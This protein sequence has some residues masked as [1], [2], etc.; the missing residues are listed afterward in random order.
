MIERKYSCW[1]RCLKE[2]WMKKKLFKVRLS[3]AWRLTWHCQDLIL[4]TD[5]VSCWVGHL[6]SFQVQWPLMW[7]RNRQV[8]SHVRSWLGLLVGDC[9]YYCHAANTSS[10][11]LAICSIS[12]VFPSYAPP[13][14]SLLGKYNIKDNSQTQKIGGICLQVGGK[15]EMWNDGWS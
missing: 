3:Q 10:S 11:A 5:W 7:M 13:H 14:I 15:C 12:F 4:A 1:L 9:S 8:R 6:P 2:E